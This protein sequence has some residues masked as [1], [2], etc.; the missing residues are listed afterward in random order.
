MVC[1]YT[2]VQCMILIQ[3]FSTMSFYKFPQIFG[4]VLVAL[5]FRTAK[6]AV[7]LANN[8]IYGLGG[9]VWTEDLALAVEVARNVKT[10]TMWINSHNIFD[11]AAG[12]GGYK[13]SGFGRDGGK[14]VLFSSWI[15]FIFFH[16]ET[17]II[18]LV[19]QGLFE[20]V[21][22][23]WDS[24]TRIQDLNIADIIKSYGAIIADVPNFKKFIENGP[25]AQEPLR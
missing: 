17:L 25:S 5:P 3:F 6:E 21:K 24:I 4:P 1:K 2:T 14:E 10:G 8:S 20:Y 15:Q 12:F 19:Y 22:P 9:S 16:C 23:A 13:Q 7:S 18:T 11:A